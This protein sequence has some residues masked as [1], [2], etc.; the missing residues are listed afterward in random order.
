QD[1]QVTHSGQILGT[2]AYMAPEQAAGR[3]HQVGPLADVY[4]LGALLYH[5]LCKRPPFEGSVGEI[6]HRVQSAEPTPPRK[7][8]PTVHRDLET[9]CLKAMAKGP[10]DRYP[11]AGD[12][13]ADLERFAAGEAI[14]ARRE[15]WLARLRRGARRNPVA[16]VAGL[17]LL[18]G[19]VVLF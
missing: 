12:L 13:A 16:V 2:P 10:R 1:G 19:L 15:G 18:I 14:K 4:S 5:L 3:T 6:L 9:V 7:L 8:V 17:L 11:S